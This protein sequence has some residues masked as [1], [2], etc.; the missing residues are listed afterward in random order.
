[1][2]INDYLYYMDL[3]RVGYLERN[4]N[5]KTLESRMFSLTLQSAS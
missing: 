2:S 4:G 3:A 1:M 5:L